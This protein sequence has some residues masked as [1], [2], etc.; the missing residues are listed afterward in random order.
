[1]AFGLQTVER[2]VRSTNCVQ[3]RQSGRFFLL[4]SISF[5]FSSFLPV[6][7]FGALRS[8]AY[9][10]VRRP[11]I[12]CNRIS[13]FKWET[14]NSNSGVWSVS[15][16]RVGFFF[17]LCAEFSGPVANSFCATNC[18]LIKCFT[19]LTD[20]YENWQRSVHPFNCVVIICEHKHMPTL[21]RT[22]NTRSYEMFVIFIM[23]MTTRRSW[24]QT[25]TRTFCWKIISFF[26]LSFRFQRWNIC[27]RHEFPLSPFS[28]FFHICWHVVAHR[29]K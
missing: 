2:T 20:F 9:T 5:S 25:E 17:Y 15:S 1:M 23:K 21:R 16:R 24:T 19:F 27:G 12:T 22:T 3:M 29:V 4:F 18:E 13:V 11:M 26:H 7:Q 10:P 14:P 6:V 8:Q 28:I